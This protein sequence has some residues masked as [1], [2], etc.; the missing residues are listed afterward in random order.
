VAS[1]TLLQNLGGA[2][3]LEHKPG[4]VDLCFN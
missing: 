3:R 4:S 2:T 1:N